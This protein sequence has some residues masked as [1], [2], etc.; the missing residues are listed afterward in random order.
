MKDLVFE[1]PVKMRLREGGKTKRIVSAQEAS[2]LLEST[3]L[4]GDRTQLHRDAYE[5]ADDA[6]AGNRTAENAHK[7]FVPA[8]RE[9]ILLEPSSDDASKP[10]RTHFERIV[11]IQ[12]HG[13]STVR[14]VK[15]VNG[16][17]EIMIDWSH[18]KRGA[19]SAA[20]AGIVVE[21]G[22]E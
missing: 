5:V 12:P 4:P 19:A 18:V 1:T 21:R 10:N 7:A 15:S 14:E 22:A 16:A 9:G 11:C 17:C 13:G 20:H 3:D 6:F 2:V 8:A